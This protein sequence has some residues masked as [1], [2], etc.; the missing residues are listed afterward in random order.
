MGIE[1]A[2]GPDGIITRSGAFFL[3]SCYLQPPRR[4]F[5]RDASGDA[6]G[7]YCLE[8]GRWWRIN[9]TEDI[10][11]RL[12]KRVCQRDDLSMNVF[13]LLGMVA[14]AMTVHAGER[15]DYSGQSVLM[16]GDNISAVDW[17]SRC[18]GGQIT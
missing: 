11:A 13:E 10:R 6:M 14:W 15:P 4:I 5:V 12:R 16:R 18:R 1:M 2:T 3:S 8:T 7:G 17:V 9:F